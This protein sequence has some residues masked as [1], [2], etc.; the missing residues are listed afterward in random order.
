MRA[1]FINVT[2]REISEVVLDDTIILK[3]LQRYV[4][5]YIERALELPNGDDLFVD[6]EGLLK[7][8]EYFFMHEAGHQPFAGNGIIVGH[9]KEGETIAAR[10]T[11]VDV[12]G[13]V[14]FMLA[15]RGA[16]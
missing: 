6:E 14:D 3:E 10:S 5:G 13:K 11:L 16:K 1:I 8:P 4:G 15:K 7:S 12:I 9:D 2:K